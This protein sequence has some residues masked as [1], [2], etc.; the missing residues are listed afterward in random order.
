MGEA[1]GCTEVRSGPSIS[2]RTLPAIYLTRHHHSVLAFLPSYSSLAPNI[3]LVPIRTIASTALPPHPQPLT[4][5]RYKFSVNDRLK[6]L[7]VGRRGETQRL[8][9][10]SYTDP[11]GVLDAQGDVARSCPT[12]R[13]RTAGLCVGSF[14]AG[15]D[16][17]LT[18]A[19]LGQ[20][21]EQRSDGGDEMRS[22]GWPPHNLFRTKRGL[23]HSCG[24]LKAVRG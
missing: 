20:A 7:G 16:C 19:N 9:D 18:S 1:A 22:A 2:M 24:R 8:L 15:V 10:P 17:L 11:V 3:S 21:Q 23:L 5:F 4:F 14:L 12:G 6:L 13:P